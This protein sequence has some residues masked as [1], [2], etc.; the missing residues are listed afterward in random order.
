M[1]ITYS[2]SVPPIEDY[3]NLIESTGWQGILTK[4]SNKLN[5][6]I[7]N[8]W[9]C[10][11]AID[12]GETVGYGRILSDGVLHAIICDL[13]VL[14]TYQG[15]GIGSSIL[16]Q[17][18]RKCHE[19]EIL[20]IQLFAAKDKYNYYKRFGFEERPADAPGMRWMKNDNKK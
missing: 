7:M 5:E 9:Y 13:I 10:V 14:P 19:N 17:L 20:M 16:K 11:S 2:E 15:K 8:S 12:N 1:N 6:S 3:I 18:L 4:G